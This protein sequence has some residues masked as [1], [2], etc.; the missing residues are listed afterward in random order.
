MVHASSLRVGVGANAVAASAKIYNPDE[1]VTRSSRE[2]EHQRHSRGWLMFVKRNRHKDKRSKNVADE[3]DE[4]VFSVDKWRGLLLSVAKTATMYAER[5]TAAAESERL[6]AQ[7]KKGRRAR[8]A[9]SE[10]AVLNECRAKA[11]VRLAA[12]AHQLHVRQSPNE[13]CM[14]NAVEE[15]ARCE[16]V[17]LMFAA[18]RL[19]VQPLSE[20]VELLRSIFPDDVDA[21]MQGKE[22]WSDMVDAALFAAL[23]DCPTVEEEGAKHR[24]DTVSGLFRVV[25][26]TAIE[27]RMVQGN[28]VKLENRALFQTLEQNERVSEDRGSTKR[29]PSID[30]DNACM[31]IAKD[32]PI[33]RPV[34]V[35]SYSASP[36]VENLAQEN[37]TPR[38]SMENV[39]AK[40]KRV[41]RSRVATKSKGDSE[42][43]RSNIGS[44][45]KT[46]S[47]VDNDSIPDF[48]ELEDIIVPVTEIS[49]RPNVPVDSTDEIMAANEGESESFQSTEAAGGQGISRANER[50]DRISVA[51][52]VGMTRK[53]SDETIAAECVVIG[54]ASTKHPLQ[55][56]AIVASLL[57]EQSPKQG[58]RMPTPPSSSDEGNNKDLPRIPA[59]RANRASQLSLRAVKKKLSID[60]R[61]R[62]LDNSGTVGSSVTAEESDDAAAKELKKKAKLRAT[63]VSR[64]RRSRQSA[65][66]SAGAGEESRKSNR[67]SVENLPNV[68][69]GNA[70]KAP[71]KVKRLLRKRRTGTEGLAASRSM[72]HIVT[73]G[74]RYV[75]KKNV[76]DGEVAVR[77]IDKSKLLTRAILL[78]CYP[79][80]SEVR[81][82]EDGTC[83]LR[84]SDRSNALKL[85]SDKHSIAN[86]FGKDAVAVLLRV[87]ENNVNS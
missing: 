21:V 53:G 58:A 59:S 1:S 11:L 12:L 31:V 14:L 39:R 23:T 3:Q 33:V 28:E 69:A 61:R 73:F 80:V 43:S 67:K 44:E 84:F 8:N 16:M 68:A 82:E 13:F 18:A 56:P 47:A 57:N 37:S 66:K 65:E 27:N 7:E 2:R 41:G 51:Q 83:I 30:A 81:K 79:G 46:E 55:H 10:K 71:G 72:S 48:A 4:P 35:R 45:V 6:A 20:V 76:D 78:T 70:K 42:K 62:S 74:R 9:A 22:P 40:N 77:G 64:T 52:G 36:V 29:N 17:S 87:K 85:L 63:F 54:D 86:T 25:P 32:V 50:A 75:S 24:M 34:P 15:V 49:A 19:D 26:L 5:Y 60:F 38:P